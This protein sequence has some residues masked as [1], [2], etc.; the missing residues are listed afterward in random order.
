MRRA[1]IAICLAIVTSS[2]ISDSA[3]AEARR[4]TV[5]VYNWSDYIDPSVI[6]EFTK[7]TGIAVRYDTFDSNDVLEAK[8]LAG[9]SG[10]DVVVPTA[11]FLERQIKAGVF[12]KLDKAKLPNLANM[13]PEITERLAQYDPG[14]LYGVNYMWGTTGIGYNLNKS[15]A[16][17]GGDGRIDSWDA[18]FKP[19]QL[20]KFKDCGVHLLD[21]SDDL[22][23]AALHYLGLDPN[24]K[25]EADYQKAADLLM[26]VRPSVRKFH[27]SEYLSALASGEICFA[28]GFSGDVKQA[29]KRA[30]EAR[31][32]VEIAYAIPKEGAQL[33]FDNLAIPRDAR[34]VAEAHEFIN[35]LQQPEVAARNSSF[36]AY[37]NGNLASQKFIDKAVIE[38]PTIYP[39]EATMSR[40]YI[41]RAHD[42]ATTRL[43]NRLWTR[44]KTGR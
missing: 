31:N 11:Y 43:M 13:W 20:A 32:G 23:S 14:N 21:S 12:A 33:W 34:N 16:L 6:E 36:I 4:R 38:D 29:Q 44:V 27:S 8:L 18:V 22:M 7:A 17:L 5:N 26:T 1:L 40:L 39:D 2:L 35:F 37:A 9:R 3:A 41:M 24:T 30:A 25:R 19:E 28:V 15:R 10:Y 42:A